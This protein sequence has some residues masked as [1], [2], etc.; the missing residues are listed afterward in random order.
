MSHARHVHEHILRLGR[1]RN[2]NAQQLT[3]LQAFKVVG[4][5]AA[6]VGARHGEAALD[7][8]LRLVLAPGQLR[9]Q[10]RQ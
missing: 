1:T 3:R 2:L 5:E 7:A 6:A 8:G 9:R 4:R 10:H